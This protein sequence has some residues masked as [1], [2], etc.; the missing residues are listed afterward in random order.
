MSK[1]LE[2]KNNAKKTWGVLKQL[3]GKVHNT[4]SSSPKKLVTDKKEITEVIGIAEKVNNV[5]TNFGPN[6]AEKIQIF[7]TQLLVS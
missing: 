5:F 3:I 1:I 6:L 2:L 7:Q 4:E